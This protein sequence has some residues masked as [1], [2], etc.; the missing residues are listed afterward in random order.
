M[1]DASPA[2]DAILQIEDLQY[3]FGG[4]KAVNG[5]SFSIERGW[6]NALIGPNG[7]GKTT[8]INVISGALRAQAGR[9]RFEGTNITGWPSHRVA[10]RGLIRT[11]QISR[12]LGGMTVLENMLVPPPRQAG[13]RL[14]NAMFRPAIGRAQDALLVEKALEQLDDFGLYDSRDQYARNLSGGQK[15]LLELAR[16][17]MADP[18]LMVLDEPFAGVNP[19]LIELLEGHIQQLR[20]TG[21]TFIMVEHNLNVVERICDHVVVMAEGRTLATGRLAELRTNQEVITAYLGGALTAHPHATPGRVVELEPKDASRGTPILTATRLTAGYGRVPVVQE[22]DVQAEPGKVVAIVGPNGAGKSTLLK[23]V[24]GLLRN[25][26]GSVKLADE[27]IGGWPAFRIAR[28]GMAYVPQ[29]INVF[30]N[31]SV[32]ENLEMG[33]YTLESGVQKRVEEVLE[34]FPDLKLARTKKAVNLSGGQRNMLGMARALML[35]PK[36]VLLD[37]PTAGLSPAYT[38]VVWNQIRRVA[39]LGTAVVVVEQNVDLAVKNADWV[40]VLVAGRNRLDGPPNVVGK[41]DLPSIFL[42]GELPANLATSSHSK[43]EREHA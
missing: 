25:S 24:F 40:Y 28:G 23:A 33:G 32:H 11:F 4:L 39:G 20:D 42:G 34:I 29:V 35:E 15:R 26:S 9:V 30:T 14:F 10:G 1:T 8:L 38:G 43:E 19:A 12:E 13:E 18:K 37:E 6:I 7:A 27:E 2:G 22:V 16:G 21:I 41:E 31:L 5:S 36:V 3:A 17:V